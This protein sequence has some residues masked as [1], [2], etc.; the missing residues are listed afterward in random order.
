MA[1][2][3]YK[4]SGETRWFSGKRKLMVSK[5]YPCVTRVGGR[6]MIVKGISMLW[7]VRVTFTQGHRNIQC[8]LVSPA[9]PNIVK[10]IQIHPKV[11]VP[12]I[13]LFSCGWDTSETHITPSRWWST[14]KLFFWESHQHIYIYIYTCIYIYVYIIMYIYIYRERE[15]ERDM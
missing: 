14:L 15:K 4:R 7:A 5:A 9:I 6:A 13:I 10:Y 8:C 1:I 3:W 2:G 12:S 11:L